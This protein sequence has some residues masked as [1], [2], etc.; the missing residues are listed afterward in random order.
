MNMNYKVSLS[1]VSAKYLKRTDQVDRKRIIQALEGLKYNPPI[2][3]IL[4]MKGMT[5]HYR[6]RVGAYRI[7][8][9]VDHE[10]ML[11]IVKSIG[12]RGDVYK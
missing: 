5:D 11:I 7:I 9:K 3:D 10:N 6:L 4:P 1:R 2:G 8:F 12:P